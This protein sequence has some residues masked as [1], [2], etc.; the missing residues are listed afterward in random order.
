M[1]MNA[2]KQKFKKNYGD[3]LFTTPQ[4]QAL[5]TRLKAQVVGRLI[6]EGIL[7]QA[8]NRSGYKLDEDAIK[9]EL[10]K[11]LEKNG[12]NKKE[13]QQSLEESGYN[14]GYFI[15]KLETG[16]LINR[17]LDEKIM[18]GASTPY[19]KQRLFTSWFNNSKTLSE[20]VYYDKDV[21]QAV[22]N[23][24]ASGSCCPAK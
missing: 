6:D 15:R 4:G 23:Q 14:Y 10:V 18:A 16:L 21:K 12:K 17:F 22:R 20:I 1:E 2:A 9:T 3:Q 11:Y 5:E 13:F 19:E 7:L 24:S 8:I